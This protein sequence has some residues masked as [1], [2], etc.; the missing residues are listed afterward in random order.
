MATL[1]DPR[2][3]DNVPSLNFS[4]EHDCKLR[5]YK[6]TLVDALLVAF[7]P[8]SGGT[9]EAQGEGRG[10]GRGRQRSLGTAST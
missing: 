3:K 9:V 8:D 4:L 5:E 10:G 6:R 7:P 2:Y 1:L